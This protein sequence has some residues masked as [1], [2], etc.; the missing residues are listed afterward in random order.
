MSIQLIPNVARIKNEKKY[1]MKYKLDKP[2]ELPALTP[3][4]KKT[5]NDV[6]RY[7]YYRE[8]IFS[9]EDMLLYRGIFKLYKNDFK[10]A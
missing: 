9:L 7:G 10:G 4:E 5:L 1:V 6:E 2:V 3:T 8:N